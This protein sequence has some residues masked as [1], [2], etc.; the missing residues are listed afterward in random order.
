MVHCHVMYYRLW[1]APPPYTMYIM[2]HVHVSF[3]VLRAHRQ[4]PHP[5]LWV[6]SHCVIISDLV[7]P[8]FVWFVN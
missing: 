2:L 5:L 7:L 6:L 4:G 3:T 1:S 8:L